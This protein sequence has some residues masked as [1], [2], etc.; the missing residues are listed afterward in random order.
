MRYTSLLFTLLLPTVMRAQ[1]ASSYRIT[2]IDMNS[3]EPKGG[4]MSYPIRRVIVC[5]LPAKL[6]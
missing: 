6:A 4:T 1:S 5:T 2:H 3:V